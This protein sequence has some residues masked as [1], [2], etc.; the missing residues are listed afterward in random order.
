MLWDLKWKLRRR[1][2]MRQPRTKESGTILV[3][4]EQDAIKMEKQ[5]VSVGIEAA[6]SNALK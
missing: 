4:S 5:A 1:L 6:W 3:V 2:W